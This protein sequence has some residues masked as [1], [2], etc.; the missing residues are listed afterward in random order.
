M[1][2]ERDGLSDELG[3]EP[4]E[5]EVDENEAD[6]SEPASYR[7]DE[8]T[9]AAT[10]YGR[11]RE[12]RRGSA[13]AGSSNAAARQQLALD[14]R[15][16]GYSF[17]AIAAKCGFPHRS[18]ARRAVMAA[19]KA[20][21]EDTAEEARLTFKASYGPVRPALHR[22]AR[23][24]DPRAVEALVKLDERECRLFGLDLTPDA[25]LASGNYTKRIIL[26]MEPAATLPAAADGANGWQA[27]HTDVNGAWPNK[28]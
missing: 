12:G 6:M 16:Q 18:N 27:D 25:A 8:A 5:N 14:L 23:T 11:G 9:H 26:E 4:D 10:Q 19:I 7:G 22:R 2:T 24:G 28:D 21:A 17:D 1:G 13:G 15:G 20:L 3:I